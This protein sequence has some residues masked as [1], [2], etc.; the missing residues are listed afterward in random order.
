MRN[1]ILTGFFSLMICCQ[2][3][4]AQTTTTIVQLSE[5]TNAN[6]LAQTGNIRPTA[7]GTGYLIVG[8]S[9]YEDYARAMVI[10]TDLNY[11]PIWTRKLD[12]PIST[13]FGNAFRAT[14]GIDITDLGD[15]NY[16]LL[17]NINRNVLSNSNV[18]QNLDYAL[19]RF[20]VTSTGTTTVQWAKTY[21]DSFNDVAHSLLKT[22][23]GNL[24]VSGYSNPEYGLLNIPGKA[25][26]FLVKTTTNGQNLW[27]NTYWDG[28][29]NTTL[30]GAIPG[31]NYRPVVETSDGNYVFA[32]ICDEWIYISK[33]NSSGVAVWTKQMKAGGA[34]GNAFQAGNIGGLG[35]AILSGGTISSIQELPNGE[36]AF[37]GNYVVSVVAFAWSNTDQ[38]PYVNGVGIP[39]GFLF[40]TSATGAFK[41]GQIFFHE[42]FGDGSQPTE[43]LCHDFKVLPNGQMLV[44]AGVGQYGNNYN[45]ALIKI[46][47]SATAIDQAVLEAAVLTNTQVRYDNNDNPRGQSQIQL[48]AKAND[49]GATIAF[50]L[51][52]IVRISNVSQLPTQ[53]TC[54]CKLTNVRSLPIQLVLTDRAPLTKASLV[55][56]SIT[57]KLS[58]KTV[59]ATTLCEG[60][61]LTAFNGDE[62]NASTLDNESTITE[63]AAMASSLWSSNIS[64]FPNP[65]NGSFTISLGGDPS[66]KEI[67][68]QLINTVGQ[69]VH[70]DQ[71]D[72]KDANG[73]YPIQFNQLTDGVYFLQLSSGADTKVLRMV[74][75]NG[76]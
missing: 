2:T 40:T 19:V 53:N 60:T 68:V 69:I 33:V 36:L 17:A 38:K 29:C 12:F 30:I 52:N 44:V 4:L 46:N 42:R 22:S 41:N 57:V 11:K 67:S 7:D 70:S 16:V 64:I 47:T 51:K 66:E 74:V 28:A 3:I 14:Y 37:M 34:I 55:K 20:K 48:L 73:L 6:A 13:P 58:N 61:G 18:L 75:Q 54:M 49:E 56:G 72:T 71:I 27:N 15:G 35:G 9:G 39:M 45:P 31:M 63:R 8:T 23:D 5:S 43:M 76:G 26:T 59:T 62:N 21:G 65:N 50:N 32:T 1:L 25:R 10:R 24:L